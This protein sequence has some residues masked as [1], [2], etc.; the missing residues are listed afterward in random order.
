MRPHKTSIHPGEQLHEELKASGLTAAEF[1]RKLRVPVNRI[2]RILNGQ[3]SISADTALRVA[4]FFGTAPEFWLG[5]QIR[6]DLSVA[7][8]R[9]GPKL[10]SLPKLK[11]R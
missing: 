5:L 4:H 11:R 8:R 6:F 3:R 7:E 9:I 1:A 10:N 2:T